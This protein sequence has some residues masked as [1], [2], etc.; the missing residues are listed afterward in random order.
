MI[1]IDIRTNFP[2]VAR[3]L[4]RVERDIGEK[5]LARALNRTIEQ[6]RTAMV[7][8]ITAEYVL[9]SATVR[10]RLAIRRAYAGA[11]RIQL[12]ASLAAPAKSGRRAINV[13]AFLERSVTLAEAR[14]R[15]KSG[16][17]RQLRFKIRRTGGWKTIPGAFLGNQ[18]RT[19]F[20]RVGKARLPIEPVS[21]IDVPQ[22]FNA[23]RINEAVR[24]VLLARFQD[25]FARELRFALSSR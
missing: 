5:A 6:G 17:L 11:Q 24:R 1:A 9:P 2:E 8:E 10:S 4:R 21:T 18:G 3:A 14:R 13:V 22:M 7:R 15:A 12:E 20:R 16:T 23:R 19:V 25:H